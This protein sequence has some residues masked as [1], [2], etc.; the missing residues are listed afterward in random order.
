MLNA[1]PLRYRPLYALYPGRAHAEES[2]EHQ[3][4]ETLA[5]LK[6]LGRAPTDLGLAHL[7]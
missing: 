2:L 7:E 5:L 4:A 3:I 1:T 6:R